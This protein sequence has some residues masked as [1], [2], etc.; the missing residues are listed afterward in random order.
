MP[1]PDDFENDT[2]A[3]RSASQTQGPFGTAPVDRL[4]YRKTIDAPELRAAAAY[5]P[6][7]TPRRDFNATA[8]AAPARQEFKDWTP[9]A[10]EPA[11]T[12]AMPEPFTDPELR[13]VSSTARIVFTILAVAIPLLLVGGAIL[14]GLS[15]SGV[16]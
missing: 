1:D 12:A 7:S 4:V 13:T 11:S 16:L 6:V 2:D 15:I 8:P 9:A 3:S 10:D 5:V 14:L